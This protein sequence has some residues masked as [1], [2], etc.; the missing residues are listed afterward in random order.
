MS[1]NEI[2]NTL[3]SNIQAS[4]HHSKY[5]H[6]SPAPIS[7]KNMSLNKLPFRVTSCNVVTIWVCAILGPVYMFMYGCIFILCVFQ[8]KNHVFWMFWN[9]KRFAAHPRKITHIESTSPWLLS[10]EGTKLWG[11]LD[12]HPQ[13]LQRSI[14]CPLVKSLSA[15]SEKIDLD[16]IDSTLVNLKKR[17]CKCL[18]QQKVCRKSSIG[19]PHQLRAVR[20]GLR[21]CDAFSMLM[22]SDK[23][24]DFH[25][26]KVLIA[27]YSMFLVD[28]HWSNSSCVQ[29]D[30]FVDSKVK[31][32]YNL[33]SCIGVSGGGNGLLKGRVNV[34]VTNRSPFRPFIP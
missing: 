3:L 15:K 19:I 23:P 26:F 24:M 8:N 11:C 31:I 7:W 5:I 2:W 34:P 6:A 27:W 25:N 13:H 12:K 4:V 29:K 32:M 22:W 14:C 1:C 21:S 17:W 28:L 9:Q 30:Q 16:N 20:L 10:G 18:T 33:L